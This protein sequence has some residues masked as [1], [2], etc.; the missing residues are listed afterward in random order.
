MPL[1][2]TFFDCGDAAL[3]VDFGSH[4]DPSLSQA[5]LAVSEAL[6]CSQLRGVNESIPALSTLTVFYDPLE[7]PKE[8]LIAEIENHCRSEHA[9]A[10]KPRSW[11]I[12]VVYG[13]ASGPD[14]GEVS[15]RTG[16]TSDAVVS[17]H[18]GH[19]YYVYMLGFLPGFAYLGDLPQRLRLPRRKTP[20]ARVPTGSVA[21]AT[22][23]TAVYPLESP[24][25]WHILGNT[26]VVLWD[27]S[28]SGEPLFR[29]GDWVRFKP[30]SEEEAA[31]IREKS[32]AGWAPEPQ[33][34]L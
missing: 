1:R 14:L 2:P 3:L 15:E 4:Y 30:V 34:A 16:L 18:A 28:R 7:L 29:P 23:M 25:G 32:R 10:T 24:G 11:D 19:T 17:L 5:I 22:D 9:M 33:E 31:E 20:R 6:T 13:G 26:P 21:I 8:N 12:P 27:M